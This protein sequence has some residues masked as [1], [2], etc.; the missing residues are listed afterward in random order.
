MPRPYRPSNG[1]EGEWFQARFCDQ[2]A[3]DAEYRQTQENGCEILAN[4]LCFGGDESGFP[5]EWVEDDDGQN[6]RCT[7]FEPTPNAFW[8]VPP[9]S[10]SPSRRDQ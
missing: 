4:A 8:I 6:Q 7:A 5:N 1:S 2:C 9:P 10:V 3:R